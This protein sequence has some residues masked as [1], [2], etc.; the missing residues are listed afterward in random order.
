M[1]E[2][3]AKP[4]KA[5]AA[6]LKKNFNKKQILCARFAETVNRGLGSFITLI[7]IVEIAPMKI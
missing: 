1:S 4:R 3:T 7:A 6:V 2:V 5:I